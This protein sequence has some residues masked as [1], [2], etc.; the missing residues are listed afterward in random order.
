MR[1]GQEPPIRGTVIQLAK[2]NYLVYTQGYVPFLR[3]Y[4][5]PRIP[6]PLE[7]VEHHGDSSAQRVCSEILA[8][9]KLNW[10]TCKFASSEPITIAFSRRVATIIKE[11]PI[12]VEPS[13]K[14]RFYM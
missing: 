10:N 8:L 9:T 12:E 2:T 3:Q 13:T 5:G 6:N 11:L 1:L 14:Y 7:V 4:P